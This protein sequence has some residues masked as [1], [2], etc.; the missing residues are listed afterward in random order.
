MKELCFLDHRVKIFRRV[1][2][3]SLNSTFTLTTAQRCADWMILRQFRFM[4]AKA[5]TCLQHNHDFLSYLGTG[6]DSAGERLTAERFLLHYDSLFSSKV[7]AEAMMRS[8][9]DELFV[10]KFIPSIPITQC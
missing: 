3:R 6:I 1:K 2:D 7:S 8:M 10:L 4:E 5:G 9:K